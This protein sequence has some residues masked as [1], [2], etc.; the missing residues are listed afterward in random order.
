MPHFQR[1]L[2]S[3]QPTSQQILS[4]HPRRGGS[5]FWSLHFLRAVVPVTIAVIMVVFAFMAIIA[6]RI[7][8]FGPVAS[9]VAGPDLAAGS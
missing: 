4:R 1:G 6:M 3:L 5:F 9:T 7:F 8:T 2:V